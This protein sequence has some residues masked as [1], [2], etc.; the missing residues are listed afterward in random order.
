LFQSHKTFPMDGDLIKKF[1]L[2]RCSTQSSLLSHL[3]HEV[4]HADVNLKVHCGSHLKKHS[5]QIYVKSHSCH[6]VFHV[7]RILQKVQFIIHSTQSSVLS[8][9]CHEVLDPDVNL[10]KKFI[11]IVISKSIPHK[12]TF[13]SSSCHWSVPQ[14]YDLMKKF[15][16]TVISYCIPHRHPYIHIHFMKCATW[17]E[18]YRNVWCDSYIIMHSTQTS[19]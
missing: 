14:K 4:F 9:L 10:M 2:I 8:H 6:K 5:T 19:I 1:Y 11:V 15:I 13:K 12:F 16:V 17:I 7:D 3:C 18:T